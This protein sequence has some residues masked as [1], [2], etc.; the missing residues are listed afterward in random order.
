MGSRPLDSQPLDPWA[1]YGRNR[2]ACDAYTKLP[3]LHSF[4]IAIGVEKI[5][6]RIKKDFGLALRKE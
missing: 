6:E 4:V 3:D 1:N 5:A 2:D